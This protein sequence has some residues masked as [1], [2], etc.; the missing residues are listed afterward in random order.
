MN[1]RIWSIFGHRAKSTAAL[2][3]TPQCQLSDKHYSRSM[4]TI[5]F[6]DV[7]QKMIQSRVSGGVV[8]GLPGWQEGAVSPAVAEL[9]DLWARYVLHLEGPGCVHWSGSS[10]DEEQLCHSSAWLQVSLLFSNLR[11]QR[12]G[13]ADN[14]LRSQRAETQLYSTAIVGFMYFHFVLPLVFNLWFTMKI[15]VV[16]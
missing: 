6:S 9:F 2:E 12:S 3:E 4:F 1:A 11:N 13:Q 5:N 14:P 7:R 10:E 16:R 15:K 8:Q